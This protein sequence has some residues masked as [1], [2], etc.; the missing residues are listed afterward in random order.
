MGKKKLTEKDAKALRER[1]L[2]AE[3]RNAELELQLKAVKKQLKKKPKLIPE[4]KKASNGDELTM[5]EVRVGMQ[6]QGKDNDK[7]WNRLLLIVRF[8][9][10]KYLPVSGTWS[11]Y[12]SNKRDAAMEAIA[13]DCPVFRR[14]EG[15]WP[16]H[17]IVRQ[18]LQNQISKLRTALL[19]QEAFAKGEERAPRRAGRQKKAT[20]AMQS[21]VEEEMEEEMED[22]EDEQAAEAPQ[23]KRQQSSS[24]A[25]SK[26]KQ[27]NKKLEPDT[28]GSEDDEFGTREG[29][30][31]EEAD[32]EE[33]KEDLDAGKLDKAEWTPLGGDDSMDEDE[34]VIPVKNKKSTT[35]SSQKQSVKKQVILSDEDDD[36]DDDKEEE[37]PQQPKK[38]SMLRVTR[39]KTTD[40]EPASMNMSPELETCPNCTDAV[41]DRRSSRLEELLDE[42]DATEDDSPNLQTLRKTIC[43]EIKFMRG[44]EL[45]HSMSMK[46]HWPIQLSIDRI[47]RAI[48]EM[49][50][51]LKTLLTDP[52]ELANNI[53]FRR[54]LNAINYQVADYNSAFHDKSNP[55][56]KL[57][58]TVWR[59]RIRLDLT[60]PSFGIPGFYRIRSCLFVLLQNFLPSDQLSLTLS[61]VAEDAERTSHPWQLTEDGN[62]DFSAPAFIESVLVAHVTISLI[63]QDLEIDYKDALV[64]FTEASTVSKF[65]ARR[66]VS[67]LEQDIHNITTKMLT[68]LRLAARDEARDEAE[69]AQQSQA[70][71]VEIGKRKKEKVTADESQQMPKNKKVKIEESEKEKEKEKEKEN[72]QIPKPKKRE[73]TGKPG[74]RTASEIIRVELT[75]DDYKPPPIKPARKT[76]A[77]RQTL[78]TA[79]APIHSYPTRNRSKAA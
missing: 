7:E 69:N 52:E 36:E 58:E 2:A 38:S 40:Q 32:R 43:G 57:L 65:F 74:R 31:Q 41:P 20:A 26:P 25:K 63:S 56:H 47:P 22:S 42:L 30:A 44:Q 75:L 1:A 51:D 14:F 11:T 27:R 64:E 60:S 66:S 68:L 4:P 18:F 61:S 49:R 9:W 13:A 67:W 33:E 3:K 50:E 59:F 62:V 39:T 8:S 53:I 6:L 70:K 79:I 76:A 16:I 46:R 37:A 21:E 45:A 28:S 29:C 73:L 24:K 35:R 48:F 19:D 12:K 78:P 15:L 5:E 54:F 55:S 23:P 72:V 77:A 17:H 71:K 34:E 10:A